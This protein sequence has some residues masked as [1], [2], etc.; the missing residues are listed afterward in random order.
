MGFFD[1]SAL[2]LPD[3]AAFEFLSTAT[4]GVDAGTSGVGSFDAFGM[5]AFGEKVAEFSINP[6][7]GV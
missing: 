2:S 6:I 4:E 7:T 1:P 5:P 3:P